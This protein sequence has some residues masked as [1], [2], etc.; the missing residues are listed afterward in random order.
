MKNISAF[1][2]KSSHC[3]Y[4][5]VPPLGVSG[6]FHSGHDKMLEFIEYLQ[7]QVILLNKSICGCVFT[8][9]NSVTGLSNSQA[10]FRQI[11]LK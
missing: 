4:F 1:P 8:Q 6:G 10:Q 2:V 9:V 7:V 5:K 11:T 3:Q